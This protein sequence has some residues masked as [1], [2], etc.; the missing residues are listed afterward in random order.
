MSIFKILQHLCIYAW[1]LLQ[2]NLQKI[3]IPRY[4]MIE[5]YDCNDNSTMK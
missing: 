4:T 5:S 3:I 2:E 1:A